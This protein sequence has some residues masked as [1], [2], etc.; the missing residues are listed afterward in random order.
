MA[1]WWTTWLL[2]IYIQITVKLHADSSLVNCVAAENIHTGQLYSTPMLSDELLHVC[3]KLTHISISWLMNQQK[4]LT[5]ETSPCK[6]SPLLVVPLNFCCSSPTWHQRHCWGQTEPGPRG[7]AAGG[8]LASTR[9][10]HP[11]PSV[12]WWRCMSCPT[13]QPFC[14]HHCVP[15]QHSVSASQAPQNKLFKTIISQRQT[16]CL[17]H[18]VSQ[19][20]SVSA[21]QVPHNKLCLCH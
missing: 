18:C 6:D 9:R 5:E 16:F 13:N 21:S 15:Q 1:L 11:C 8:T 12:C 17:C 19:Q 4:V 7:S 14:L 3:W 2:E 20:H 10:I